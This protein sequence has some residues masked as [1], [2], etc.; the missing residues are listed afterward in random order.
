M[1]EGLILLD[2]S[3]V[4]EHLQTILG[5]VIFIQPKTELLVICQNLVYRGCFCALLPSLAESQQDFDDVSLYLLI[6]FF[7]V[8][9]DQTCV[10]VLKLLKHVF[11]LRYVIYV[12]TFHQDMD[13]AEHLVTECSFVLP[14]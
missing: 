14:S 13:L 12:Y 7:V 5:H 11:N 3:F 2:Y 6:D 8:N 1:A 10:L 4:K 9:L